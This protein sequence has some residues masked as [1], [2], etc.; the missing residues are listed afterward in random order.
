VEA[1]GAGISTVQF[2]DVKHLRQKMERV[3]AQLAEANI[4]AQA[5]LAP[6]PDAS[7]LA[8]QLAKPLLQIDDAN[9]FL[10]NLPIE[11]LTLG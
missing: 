4:V 3:I 7:F 8:A 5:G 2:T 10:A 1:T 9:K 6:T 11:T